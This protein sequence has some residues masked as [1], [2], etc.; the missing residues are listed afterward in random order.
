MS[1]KKK[2]LLTLCDHMVLECVHVAH[3]FSFVCVLSASFDLDP[4][5]PVSLDCLFLI[6][7]S[8]FLMFLYS[9]ASLEPIPSVYIQGHKHNSEP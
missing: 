8:F 6:A 2:E 7:P 1:Y 4:M 9:I 3:C 5:L